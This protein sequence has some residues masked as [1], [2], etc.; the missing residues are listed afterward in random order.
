MK[1]VSATSDPRYRDADLKIMKGME[2]PD[3]FTKQIEMSKIKGKWLD[4]W[5]D[6]RIT[7]ALDGNDDEIIVRFVISLL[8][9]CVMIFVLIDNI[10][11]Y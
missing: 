7:Q 6:T 11:Q 4:T 5:L 2:F 1:G 3:T 10:A 8:F 9:I